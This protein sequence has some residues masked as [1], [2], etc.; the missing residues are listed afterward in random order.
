MKINNPADAVKYLKNNWSGEFGGPLTTVEVLVDNSGY[1]EIPHLLMTYIDYLSALFSGKGPSSKNSEVRE[2]FNTYFPSAYQK[3]SAW[4]IFLYR[5]GLV[6]QYAPKSIKIKN[7]NIVSWHC[8]LDSSE[9]KNHLKILPHPN[10]KPKTYHL[11]LCAPEFIKDFKISVFIF[12]NDILNNSDR[13]KKFKEGYKKFQESE[14]IERIKKLSYISKE[15][16]DWL[17]DKI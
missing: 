2:Y 14:D 7:D 12:C 10:G 5:H 1:F 11:R 3:A 15:D 16:I 9:S 17:T 4:L 8:S 6:H 13:F